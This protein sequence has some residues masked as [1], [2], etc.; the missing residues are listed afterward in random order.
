MTVAAPD[1]GAGLSEMFSSLAAVSVVREDCKSREVQALVLD[2]GPVCGRACPSFAD[3]VVVLGDGTS[4]VIS[5]VGLTPLGRLD[6]QF[7][8]HSRS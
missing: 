1:A 4:G 2:A 3:V 6:H 5:T 7:V 8:L